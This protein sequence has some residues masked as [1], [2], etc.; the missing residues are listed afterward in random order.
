MALHSQ[1]DDLD[2][3]AI[4]RAINNIE[5]AAAKVETST[6]VLANTSTSY[7]DALLCTVNSTPADSPLLD[8]RIT[9]HVLLQ[10]KQVIVGFEEVTEIK[11]SLASLKEHAEATIQILVEKMSVP[12]PRVLIEIEEITKM[13]TGELLFQFNSKESADW[14]KESGVRESF[15]WAIDPMASI[16]DHSYSILAAFVPL[17]FQT[18]N[19][20]H[21][22]E[23]SS[24]NRLAGRH[25]ISARWVKPPSC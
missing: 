15:A 5:S 16:R 4:Q 12:M 7:K 3:T 25:I 24:R 8:P 14:I 19:P 10:A 23:I 22:Q 21:L 11:C 18:D 1:L 13:C 20:T 17:T 6:T 9:Q 2:S